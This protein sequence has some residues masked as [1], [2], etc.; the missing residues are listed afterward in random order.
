MIC[1]WYSDQPVGAGGWSLFFHSASAWERIG[2]P[3]LGKSVGTFPA[4]LALVGYAIGG[5]VVASVILER[6][7]L[8]GK[9]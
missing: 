1:L 8:R 2:W 9:A 5:V 4:M 7:A 6:Q 3:R